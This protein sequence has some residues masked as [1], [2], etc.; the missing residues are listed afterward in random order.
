M[1]T[2]IKSLGS[3]IRSAMRGFQTVATMS[4]AQAL[5]FGEDGGSFGRPATRENAMSVPAFWRAVN[6]IA[7]GCSKAGLHRYRVVGENG[8][9]RDTKHITYRLVRSYPNPYMS[10]H[11]MWRTVFAHAIV[12]GNGYI[13]IVRD[14]TGMA[15]ELW[16]LLPSDTYPVR[17]NGELWYITSVSSAS[18]GAAKHVKIPPDD[19]LHIKGLGYDG[20]CGYSILDI[21]R[22]ALA[23]AIAT[24]KHTNAFFKRGATLS[25]LLEAPYTIEENVARELLAKWNTMHSG[26]DNSHK[27]ALLTNG[28]K[29]SPLSV[30]ARKSQLLEIRQFDRVEMALLLGVKPH[31]VGDLTR[32]GYNSLEQEKRDFADEGLDP[33]WTASEDECDAKLLTQAEKDNY[34]HFFRWNRKASIQT[35]TKTES[36]VVR[37]LVTNGIITIDTGLALL[38][39]NPLPNGHGQVLMVPTNNVTLLDVSSPRQ[40]VN[41]YP[42]D[43][44]GP[45]DEQMSAARNVLHASLMT[46]VTH[47]ANDA[48]RASRKPDKFISFVESIESEHGDKFDRVTTPARRMIDVMGGRSGSVKSEFFAVVSDRLLTASECKP[49]SLTTRTAEAMGT[50]GDEIA[51]IVARAL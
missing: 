30:D 29:F 48:E 43:E 20:L 45:S 27:T 14:A 21:A 40:L 8:K 18:D 50:I 1:L 11:E 15:S 32:Q 10:A 42:S 13:Y 38:D 46:L 37:S 16:P 36:E 3:S 47:I 9:E 39:M 6:L 19:V 12:T 35:D 7:N 24:R 23:G 2:A 4:Q 17:K 31:Q 44:S 5:A 34:T 26:I 25:G 22:E 28:M 49:D 33:W 41:E 51:K